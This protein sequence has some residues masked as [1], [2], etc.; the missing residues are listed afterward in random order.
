[1]PNLSFGQSVADTTYDNMWF[2]CDV[3]YISTTKLLS[4]YY[5]SSLLS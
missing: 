1:M 3:N 2:L 4:A 5:G